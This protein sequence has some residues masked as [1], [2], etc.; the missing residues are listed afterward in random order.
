MTSINRLRFRNYSFETDTQAQPFYFL[1]L[2]VMLFYIHGASESISP[3]QSPNNSQ[4]CHSTK[5]FSE[6][7]PKYCASKRFRHCRSIFHSFHALHAITLILAARAARAGSSGEQ[8][9][10]LSK[11]ALNTIPSKTMRK[12]A[13]NDSKNQTQKIQQVFR[14]LLI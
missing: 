4:I 8:I 3:T 2:D 5:R 1:L 12:L 6:F 11:N 13:P 14:E 7:S 9:L 10:T